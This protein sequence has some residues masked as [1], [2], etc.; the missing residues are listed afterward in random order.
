[1]KSCLQKC[2]IPVKV[3]FCNEYKTRAEAAK[4]EKEIK[5]W[6]QV[7]KSDFIRKFTLNPP[8]ADEKRR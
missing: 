1:M 6:S 4:K 2:K 7:K 3:V 8:R 5:G